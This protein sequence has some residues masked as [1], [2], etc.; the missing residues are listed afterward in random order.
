MKLKLI[1]KINE[2]FDVKSYV[3]SAQGGPIDW[4]AGQF[5]IYSLPHKN[6][7]VRG[8]QRFFTISSASFE[9]NIMLTT[10][11]YSEYSSTFKKALD[12]LKIGDLIEAKGPDGDFILSNTNER[13]VFIAGGIG[14]TPFHSIITG[15]NHNNLPINVTLLYANKTEEFPFK[16][17]FEQIAAENPTFKIHYVVSPNHIDENLIK[18]KVDDF[19]NKIFYVSGPEK[20]VEDFTE[21]LKGMGISEDRIK[22]DFFPGYDSI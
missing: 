7:D 5:L 18:E 21:M 12:K 16:K 17:E 11:I 13:Y 4:K 8:I 2:T 22:Q 3:F 6:P 10:H 19:Q 9:K 14:I 1:D 20:M 15:L